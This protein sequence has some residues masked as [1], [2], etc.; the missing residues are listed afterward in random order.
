MYWA[1]DE[2]V[3]ITDSCTQK[4]YCNITDLFR[5]KKKMFY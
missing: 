3:T 4:L 5:N 2:D 1:E